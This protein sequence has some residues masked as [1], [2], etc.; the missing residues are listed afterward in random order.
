MNKIYQFRLRVIDF[1]ILLEKLY[2]YGLFILFYMLVYIMLCTCIYYFTADDEG[3]NVE[4][5]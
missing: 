2:T 3:I 1:L 5:P 4:I